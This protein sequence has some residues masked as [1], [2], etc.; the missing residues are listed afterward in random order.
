MIE[1]IIENIEVIINNQKK[2][3]P[4]G[5]TLEELSKLEQENFRYPVLLARVD[6][7]LKELSAKI[8]EP[9]K[10]EFLDL[11]SREGNRVHVNGLKFILQYAI[12]EL[13]GPDKNMKIQHSID[14]GIYVEV[15]FGLTAERLEKIRM[16]MNDLVEK[17]LN[18]SEVHVE[19]TDAISYFNQLG[20]ESKVGVMRYNTNTYVNLYRLGNLYNY[21]YYFMPT[22][23][24]YLK[25][26]D[27]TLVSENGFILRFPTVYIHD[28]I[29]EYEHHPHMFD[30]FRECRKW[31]Q[32]M[33]V[34]N[35]PELNDKV[36]TGKISDLIRMNEMIT[37]N[38]LLE[39]AR[40]IVKKTEVKIVLLAGPSSSGKTTTTKKLCMYLQSLGKNPKVIS[41]DDYFVEKEENPIGPDG[42]PDYE[43]LEA[44]DLKLFDDHMADLIQ[45]KEVLVPTYNFLLGKKEYNKKVQVGK[46]DLILIEG[47][48][49]LDPQ[50]LT[51]IPREKKYKIYLSALTELNMDD[52]NRI[53]TTDNRLLRRMIRDNRTRGYNVESTLRSWPSVRMGEEKYIFPYQDDADVIYNTALIYELGVLKT[54]VEPLLYSVDVNSE[55]YEEAKRL[56]NFL[57]LFLP[58]PAESIPQDSILREF[59]GGSCFHD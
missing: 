27:L 22:S 11:T 39:I 42:K 8:V 26:F 50:I 41:M 13:Y 15:N 54:Y 59:I 10:I 14:K 29:K 19:R 3:V 53:S 21:F 49:G 12:K 9:A 47:I 45:E 44:I 43:C 6:G 51:N 37:S 52:H 24:K 48:H 1:N 4:K 2:E 18:I 30:V 34:R 31:A 35:A 38:R 17:D 5:I 7:V 33:N 46:E 28:K 25:D 36:T 55:Y 32:M 20:D 57:H 58:I 40:E 56:I 23:T 16:K